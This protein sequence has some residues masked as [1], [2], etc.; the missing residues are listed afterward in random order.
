MTTKI[1][2]APDNTSLM[3][4]IWDD[5]ASPVGV[6]QIIHGIFD[7]MRNYDKLARFLN[8][9]GYIVFGID[10]PLTR[11]MT[12]FDCAVLHETG[13]MRHLINKYTLPIFLIGYGYGSFVAQYILQNTDIPA[14]AVCLI[15]SGRRYKWK[16]C[17]ARKIA[18]IGAKI[19]GPNATARFINFF[20]RHHC[21]H[22]Q[23]SPMGTYGFYL[24]L[25]NGLI[26]MESDAHFES[27]IMIICG[28][29][30]CDTPNPRFS[31][32]LYNAYNNNDLVNTTLMI[33]PDMQNKLL[34]EVNCGAIQ[35]DILSFFN[36]SNLLYHSNMSAKIN[37]TI[38]CKSDEAI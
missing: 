34:L 12:T 25:L 19:Y 8:H 7:G 18:Q 13:I 38:F 37:G 2:T 1:F 35:S 6:V 15:K 27:P 10:K 32:A 20:T 28:A 33:Y 26:K 31:R 17:L 21:G 14:N 22:T 9:N 23:K 36:D 29:N 16:L 11:T 24:S 4:A 30:D 3:C 5:V